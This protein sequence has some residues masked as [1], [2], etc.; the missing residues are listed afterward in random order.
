MDANTPLNIEMHPRLEAMSTFSD[1]EGSSRSS[2]Q[3]C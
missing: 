1:D 3:G 2:P